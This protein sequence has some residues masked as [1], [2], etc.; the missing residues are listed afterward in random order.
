MFKQLKRSFYLFSILYIILGGVLIAHP[1]NSLRALCVLVGAVVAL[2]G[3]ALLVRA[4]RPDEFA[5]LRFL[6]LP[7]GI[8]CLGAGLFLLFFPDGIIGAVPMVFG[9][10]VIFDSLV[11]L[12]DAWRLRKA[13]G[14]VGG[15]LLPL[16]VS[17]VLGALDNAIFSA[18]G[19]FRLMSWHMVIG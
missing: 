18:M 3:A 19:L 8:V 12:H 14:S 10:F 2:C 5:L 7:G 1:F 4:F 11:R 13:G 9:L 17:L 16:A 15:M 6:W